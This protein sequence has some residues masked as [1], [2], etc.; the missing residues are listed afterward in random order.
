MTV[1]DGTTNKPGRSNLTV[2][3]ITALIL[4]PVVLLLV[5]IGGWPF[6]GLVAALAVV[7]ILEFYELGR[8]RDI[9]GNVIIGLLALAALLIL[10]A[11]RDFIWLAALFVLVGGVVYILE[12]LRRTMPASVRWGRAAVTLGGLAY[13]GF[14]SAFLM[15]IRELPDALTWMLFI[16]CV[17]WGTDTLAYFGGRFWGKRPLAPRISPKKTLEGAIVGIAFGAL[18]GIGVLA[19]AGKLSAS[20]LVL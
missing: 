19:F 2:R 8:G 17:T 10:Y 20:T 16:I 12:T 11:R 7:S 15:A 14:P 3:F 9:P 1:S 6:V 18:A 4:G 13:A 5:F